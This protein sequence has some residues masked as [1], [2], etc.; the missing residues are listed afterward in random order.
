MTVSPNIE[1]T[2]ADDQLKETQALFT[3]ILNTDQKLLHFSHFVPKT[4]VMKTTLLMH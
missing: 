4:I 3:K 2:M 1:K